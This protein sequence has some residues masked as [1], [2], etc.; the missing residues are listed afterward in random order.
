MSESEQGLFELL[1]RTVVE[2][3][4][5]ASAGGGVVDYLGH[6]GVILSKVKLVAYSDFS[7]RVHDHVPEPLLL[8]EFAKQE[9]HDVSLGLFLLAVEFGREYL[10][11]VEDEVVAL[12]E[13]IY[14]VFE[15]PVL[16]LSGVLVEHHEFALIPPAGRLFCYPVLR[17]IEIEL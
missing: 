1:V 3:P 17:K 2:E 15:L 11:V 4:E 5:G 13:I 14:Y 8:V 16:Y 9:H 12:S 10:G 7:G 6:H